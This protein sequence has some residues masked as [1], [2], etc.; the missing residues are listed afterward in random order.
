V[1]VELYVFRID[2]RDL[3][4]PLAG[5]VFHRLCCVGLEHRGVG[6]KNPLVHVDGW[7]I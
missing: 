6:T 1:D 3:H 4:S 5:L 2:Q 7:E